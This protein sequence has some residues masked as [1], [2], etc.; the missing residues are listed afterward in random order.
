MKVFSLAL[1]AALFIFVSGASALDAPKGAFKVTNFGEK[2]AVTF[3][4]ATKGHVGE[5]KT[6]HHKEGT[7]YKCSNCHKAEEAGKTPSIKDA[8]HN[9]AA[10]TGACYQCHFKDSPKVKKPLKCADCHKG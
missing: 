2:D 8:A 9:K 6:C 10:G 3:D 1:L 5:C 7:D 4:H